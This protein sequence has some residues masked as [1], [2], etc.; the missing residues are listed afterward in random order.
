MIRALPLTVLGLLQYITPTVQ[1]LIGVV[2][3][4][5]QMPATRWLG[6]GLGLGGGFAAGS[7]G[8]VKLGGGRWAVDRRGNRSRTLERRQDDE[9]GPGCR[10][11]S[12]AS[13]STAT[14][15]TSTGRT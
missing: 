12:P 1:F 10:G 3:A 15:S 8:R 9:P 14:R 6:F 7:V 13:G 11:P 4:H 5:E 2:I